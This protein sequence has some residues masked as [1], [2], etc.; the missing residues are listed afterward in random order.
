MCNIPSARLESAFISLFTPVFTAHIDAYSKSGKKI[1]VALEFRPT[2]LPFLPTFSL[3]LSLSR[4]HRR[5]R[6]FPSR[7]FTVTRTIQSSTSLQI[8][9][10]TLLDIGLGFQFRFTFSFSSENILWKH[11]FLDWNSP[12]QVYEKSDKKQWRQVQNLHLD[13]RFTNTWQI[14]R[15]T[16]IDRWASSS[17]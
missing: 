13:K 14:N 7:S 1:P 15:Y 8:T 5:T 12:C 9:V 11:I 2:L 10:T 6:A 4:S 17:Y 16:S 3:F